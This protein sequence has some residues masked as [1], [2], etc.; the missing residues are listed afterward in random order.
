MAFKDP[1][2]K[3]TVFIS[4]LAVI[5]TMFSL[6][7]VHGGEIGLPGGGEGTTLEN[8]SDN[9]PRVDGGDNGLNDSSA[10]VEV[11]KSPVELVVDSF[12]E[13]D[14]F[15]QTA[16]NLATLDELS[17]LGFEHDA[18][19]FK[20]LEDNGSEPTSSLKRSITLSET[21]RFSYVQECSD[22]KTHTN[23]KARYSLNGLTHEE[24]VEVFFAADSYYIDSGKYGTL[25]LR[26]ER[27]IGDDGSGLVMEHDENNML[28]LLHNSENCYFYTSSKVEPN[29]SL[30]VRVTKYSDDYDLTIWL[31]INKPIA[32]PIDA[33]ETIPEAPSL[34]D[35]L[36][37]V[38]AFLEE[39]ALY[40]SAAG[41]AAYGLSFDEDESE[42][43]VQVYTG[44]LPLGG[45]EWSIRA[46][47]DDNDISIDLRNVDATTLLY[48]EG[49][50]AQAYEDICEF[51]SEKYGETGYATLRIG[52]GATDNFTLD[53]AERAFRDEGEVETY[54]YWDTEDKRIDLSIVKSDYFD[55]IYI[56]V[57]IIRYF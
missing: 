26:V 51:F 2:D 36:P 14:V 25:G 19:Q 20:I 41:L 15:L 1:L 42:Y 44:G 4:A 37:V 32:S 53:D 39:A 56:R 49:L 18:E 48:N 54:A 50:L 28:E 27:R 8:T 5:I 47:S 46:N 13:A 6:V 3:I 24:I 33:A 10:T 17:E 38:V 22:F 40:D 45:L 43:Y 57:G 12:H 29:E 23:Y 31:G 55:E 35:S 7:F 9:G 16:K 30:E 34:I 21:T 11:E 52:E